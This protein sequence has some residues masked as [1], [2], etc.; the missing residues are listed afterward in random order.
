[1]VLKLRQNLRDPRFLAGLLIR[2]AL[3]ALLQPAIRSAFFIPF[4]QTALGHPLDPWTAHLAAG[5]SSLSFPYGPVMYLLLAPL[6]WLGTGLDHL[7]E[8]VGFAHLGFGLSI[9]VCDLLVLEV[10]LR[11]LPGRNRQALLY[12]W[13]SPITLYVCYWHGQTDV[14]PVLLLLWSLLLTRN[15]RP[16][17]AGA[18]MGAAVAAKLTIILAVPFLCIYLYGNKRLRPL[19]LPFCAALLLTAIGL[20]GPYLASPGVLTAVF[21]SPEFDKIYVMA[22]NLGGGLRF[23]LLPV[24]YAVVVFAVWQVRRMSFELL[25]ALL[26]V[27][28]FLLLLMTPASPGW[29]LWVVPFLALVRWDHQT[30]RVL[31]WAFSLF[32]LAFHLIHSSGSALSLASLDLGAELQALGDGLHLHVRSLLF[33]T[34]I[35]SGCAMALGMAREGI[36]RNDYFRL[37]RKPLIVGIAG[38]SG[39]GKDTLSENIER[40]FG[41]HSV[42]RISGDDYHSWDR[43]KPMWQVMT[44]LNPR[45]NDLYRFSQDVMALADGK[46]VVTSRYD[47]ECG[48]FTAP[49]TI[50]PNHVLVVSGLHALYVPMLRNRYD[51]RIYLD[52]H[53]G[54]RHHFKVARDVKERNYSPETLAETMQRREVDAARFIHP[55][56]ACADLVFALQPIQD[57]LFSETATPETPVLKLQVLL[58]SGIFYEPLVRV[59]IGV[60][61]LHVDVALGPESDDVVITIE[62][63]VTAEDVALAAGKL[64]PEVDEFLDLRPG[65]QGDMAGLM[66]LVTLAQAVHALRGRIA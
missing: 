28:F 4:L 23:Y 44:H 38:D 55:Q 6:T 8:V 20:Q 18:V 15:L 39:S 45:A 56:R 25:I 40:L 19:F 65:W 2:L 63:E 3:V 49:Q 24:V 32:Y 54:L 41:S 51:L 43:Q 64:L 13:L 22:L 42:A 61:G 29:F 37:S 27:G 7:F 53:E 52:M 58:R 11:L 60:C 30:M 14:V 34:L 66:Q 12:Y 10:L 26:G 36:E 5:G 35:A 17:L 16:I 46:P 9:L 62:G 1:M 59:L 50:A 33:S 31:I 48:R 57:D 21:A 47:H